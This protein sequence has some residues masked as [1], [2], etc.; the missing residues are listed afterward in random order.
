VEFKVS[1]EGRKLSFQ[2][3]LNILEQT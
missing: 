1:D 3:T 2:V